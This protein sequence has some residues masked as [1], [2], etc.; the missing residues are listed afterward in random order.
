MT[1][2]YLMKIQLDKNSCHNKKSN[3]RKYLTYKISKALSLHNSNDK[4]F[5]V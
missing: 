5:D 3:T 1:N 2:F 4:A